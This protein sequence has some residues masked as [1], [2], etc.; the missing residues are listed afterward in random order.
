MA[1]IRSFSQPIILIVGGSE[2]G[3]DY[4][5]LGKTIAVSSVK[6]L[7]LV[8][9]MAERIKQAAL[10][11]GFQGKIIFQPSQ[12][13]SEVVKLAWQET[14]KGDVVL[15]SPGCASYDMFLDYKDRGF[16]FKKYV[17]AL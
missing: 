5:Q 7:I 15:L 6:T 9:Q 2:K 17:K 10:A 4:T 11:N 1:A 16:Q 13:M 14:K 12:Q 3:S 8:G